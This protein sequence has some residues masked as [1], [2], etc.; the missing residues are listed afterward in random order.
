VRSAAGALRRRTA[1]A[2]TPTFPLPVGLAARPARHRQGGRGRGRSRLTRQTGFSA[3][4]RLHSRTPLPSVRST[5]ADCSPVPPATSPAPNRFQQAE[6]AR[7]V[8]RP[9][10]PINGV[11]A[12]AAEGTPVAHSRAHS[13]P[14][15]K[16]RA[17]EV[18][19][20]GPSSDPA[21]G[22]PGQGAGDGGWHCAGVPASRP[23]S[24]PPS[25]SASEP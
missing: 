15:R 21:P 18:V 24:C 2:R 11:A 23:A 4:R 8:A 16:K 25:T 9:T 3:S 1:G 7:A 20:E 19:R 10:R 12:G 14:E 6:T 13:P 5:A 17:P 22:V